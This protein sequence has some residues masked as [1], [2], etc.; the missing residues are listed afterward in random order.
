MGNK[1][2]E[3]AIQQQTLRTEAEAQIDSGGSVK[4]PAYALGFDELLHELRV[5]Q[6]ELEMQNEELRRA[7]IALDTSRAHYI[8]LY[9]FAPVGYLTLN[10]DGIIIEI[11]L[12]AAKMLGVER[13]KLINRRFAKFIGDEYKDL[14]YRHFLLT[15]QSCEKYGCELPFQLENRPTAYYHLD[16][17]YDDMENITPNLRITLSDV[18]ERRHAQEKLRIA[19][20]AFETQ[21]GILV[22][23]A[24][25][26][27]LR[28]N[29]AFSCITGYSAEEVIGKTP[30]IF[31]SGL[32]EPDFYDAIVDSVAIKGHWR[33]EI[34]NKQKNGELIPLLETITAVIDEKGHLSHYVASMVDITQ[35]KQAEKILLDA[36]KNLEKKVITTQEELEKN[37]TEMTEI[38]TALNVLLKHRATD[39]FD[40]QAALAEEV[41]MTITPFL[42]KLQAMNSGRQRTIRVLSILEGNLKALVNSYGD[43]GNLLAVYQKLTPIETQ[44]AS[45]IRQGLPTKIIAA[46]LNI[47]SGTV[48]I[49]RKHIRKK[50]GL[51]NKAANLQ[52]YLLSLI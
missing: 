36:R 10:T 5:H 29:Q 51:D 12:T 25:K 48:S 40:A 38:N 19:A 41:E 47:A 22:T 13:S 30:A 16:C 14:W 24:N 20:V 11:N 17:V 21:E 23:D 8:D 6:I 34:W 7:H 46:T 35:Q 32:Y 37:K 45:M 39:K 44:V 3:P 31:R 4:K 1:K 18:T 49:H 15:K 28:V 27:I 50:L 33:G 43:E 42:K 52:S 9:D 2:N 26:V